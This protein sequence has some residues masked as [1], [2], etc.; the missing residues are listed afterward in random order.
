M[1][2]AFVNDTFLEGRGADTVIY[3]LARRLGRKN[4]V[5]VIASEANFKE[6][7]FRILRIK[8]AKLY[9]GRITDYFYF[10]KIRQFRKEI[11]A[12]NKKYKFDIFNVHHSALN[13]AFK[14]LPTVVTWHGSPKTKNVARIL[15]GKF[16]LAFL[17]RN[18]KVVSISSYLA[19][20]LSGYAPKDKI[21]IINDGVSEDFKPTWQDKNFMLFVGRHEPHKRVDEIIKLSQETNFPLF[22]AGS[23]PLTDKLRRY[24]KKIMANKV[25]F[26]GKVN[27]RRLVSLYQNCSFFVSASRWEGFGLIFLEAGACGKPSIAYNMCSMPEVIKNNRTGFLV[28]N[29]KEFREK[30][31]ELIKNRN[32]RKSMGKEAFNFSKDFSW[33][34]IAD[35]YEK[36]FK[37]IK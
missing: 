5:Y 36:L 8:A 32:L 33:D 3:E 18:P 26:L 17:R 9:Q 30:A 20:K 1:R 13:L 29:H 12:L 4:K 7:N 37:S 19:R 15:L 2:I 24:A 11:L 23:G 21:V 22:I 35:K 31:M 6:E 16:T 27:R 34:K 10:Q 28:N 25:R 14:G